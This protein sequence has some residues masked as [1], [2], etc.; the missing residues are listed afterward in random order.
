MNHRSCELELQINTDIIMS[1][2]RIFDNKLIFKLYY[3]F[4]DLLISICN[5]FLSF[6]S[7][8]IRFWRC[9]MIPCCHLAGLDTRASV[10]SCCHHAGLDTRTSVTPCCHL[11]GL[12]TRTCVTPCC[13]LAG[14]ESL[15]TRASVTP[16]DKW[17]RH[18]LHGI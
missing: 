5:F 3:R 15:D 7:K 14:L 4:H 2:R 13:H 8:L 18:Q 9:R 6:A 1:T 16:A 10:T 12:D 11:A 17:L